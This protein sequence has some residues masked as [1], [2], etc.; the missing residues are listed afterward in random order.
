MKIQDVL[1]LVTLFFL[2]FKRDSKLS[3]YFGLGSILVS[4]PLFYFQV[5]FT[6]EHLIWYSA[7]F[8]SLSIILMIF[9]EKII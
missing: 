9:K 8:I 6:A 2:I 1:F 3:L 5:F 4:I 7:A